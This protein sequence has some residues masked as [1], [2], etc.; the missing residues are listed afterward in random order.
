MAGFEQADAQLAGVAQ[1]QLNLRAAVDAGE[2]WMDADVAERAVAHCD[3]AVREIND[4]LIGARELTVRRKFGDNEDG[5][6]AA[7]R[8]V[9]AGHEY[10][11]SMKNAQRVFTN[12]AA[13][14]RA[15]GRT[16][17]EADE[18]SQQMFRGKSG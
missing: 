9:Q 5:N 7:E 14:F 13:T 1:Q 11:E 16:V 10:I 3:Q 6:A 15:A 2:L 17:T 8:Y 18:A 12:M 4:W